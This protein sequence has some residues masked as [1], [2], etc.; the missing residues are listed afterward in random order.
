MPSKDTVPFHLTK[1]THEEILK[2]RT[3][4]SKELGVDEN[5]ITQKQA[6]IALRRKSINGK[7]MLTD[8]NDILLGKIK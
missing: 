5:D 6:E 2:I 7:I 3:V 8:L 1:K 4:M